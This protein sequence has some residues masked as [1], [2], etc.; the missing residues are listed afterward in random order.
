MRKVRLTFLV[1]AAALIA[2]LLLPILRHK[3]HPDELPCKWDPNKDPN[4]PSTCPIRCGPSFNGAVGQ[5][6]DKSN[7]L[8]YQC[9]RDGYTIS[10]N[11]DGYICVWAK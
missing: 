7:K 4:I 10:Q 1:L 9:C 3:Q 11:A 2:L 8:W 6:T 5:Y